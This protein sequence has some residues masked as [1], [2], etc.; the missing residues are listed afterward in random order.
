MELERG[1]AKGNKTQRQPNLA[2][3]R[4]L[5]VDRRLFLFLSYLNEP[6]IS[7]YGWQEDMKKEREREM[8]RRE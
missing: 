5:L 3:G 6:F 1:Q 7:G 8:A 4:H 2:S